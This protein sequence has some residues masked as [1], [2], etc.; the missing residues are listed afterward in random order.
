[1]G[2]GL[3]G[4][5]DLAFTGTEAVPGPNGAN[6]KTSDPKVFEASIKALGDKMIAKVLGGSTPGP[7]TTSP[8]P[9][10]TGSCSWTGHCSGEF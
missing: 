2:I 4:E 9:S 5:K 10:P 8:T 3:T 1:M 6:W 7:T